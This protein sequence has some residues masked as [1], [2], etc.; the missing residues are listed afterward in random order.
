MRRSNEPSR[1]LSTEKAPNPDVA[2]LENIAAL[3]IAASMSFARNAVPVSRDGEPSRIL[4]VTE[5][6]KFL[7]LSPGTLNGWRLTV[8][9]QN[10]SGLAGGSFI[11]QTC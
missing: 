6:A 5:A 11:G 4:N 7:R 10:L 8:V 9:G 2:F 3:A 1:I